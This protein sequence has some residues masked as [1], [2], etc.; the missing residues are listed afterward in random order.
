MG[1]FSAN[2]HQHAGPDDSVASVT[3][4]L[5]DPHQSLH[6]QGKNDFHQKDQMP[7]SSER[8]NAFTF[9]FGQSSYPESLRAELRELSHSTC[10]CMGAG[11]ILPTVF[12]QTATPSIPESLSDPE[13]TDIKSANDSSL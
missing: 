5:P 11:D 2:L 9:P 12:E 13:F 3:R 1:L 7:E 10:V 4:G 8:I 6:R